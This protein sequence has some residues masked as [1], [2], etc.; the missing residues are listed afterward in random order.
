MPGRG[1][2][3]SLR[4]LSL[5]PGSGNHPVVHKPTSQKYVVSIAYFEFK[6]LVEVRE[7]AYM[8]QLY[9]CFVY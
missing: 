4:A 6:Q 3:A 2:K 9:L 8:N 7:I 5:K 1:V